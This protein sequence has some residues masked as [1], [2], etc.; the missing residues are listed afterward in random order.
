MFHLYS[1]HGFDLEVLEKLA[2][3][4]N[5]TLDK[6]SFKECM[7]KMKNRFS[8]TLDCD[9]FNSVLDNLGIEKTDNS[10]KYNYFFDEQFQEYH[11]K[12]LKTKILAIISDN[13]SM[14]NTKDSTSNSAFLIVQKSPFYV[15]S[16]GQESDSGFLLRDNIKYPLVSL[17]V[18]K[19]YLLH[20]IK[21][22]D[23]NQAKYL[24]VGDDIEMIVDCKKRTKIIRNHSGTHLFNAAIRK[25]VPAPIYQ[26]SSLVSS[27]NFKIELAVFGQKLNV[28]HVL[29]IEKFLR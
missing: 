17:S 11:I 19:D 3:I 16:G 7:Q 18:K 2:E 22:T 23:L 27:E 1:T 6:P 10:D 12:P 26:K 28:D 20:E 4:E 14:K 8:V 15:E 9:L 25:L 13:M 24:E 29:E 5:M 21:L